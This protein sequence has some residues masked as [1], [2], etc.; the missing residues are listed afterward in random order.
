VTLRS[1]EIWLGNYIRN[2]VWGVT[3]WARSDITNILFCVADHFEPIAHGP[4]TAARERKRMQAWIDGYQKLAGRHWDSDGILPQHT[5]FYPAENYRAEYLEDLSRL[6]RMGL[7]E[8]ELHLHHG[9]DTAASLRRHLE[10]ALEKFNRH[11]ALITQG[12]PPMRTYGFIHGSMALDNSM[13]DPRWCGVNNELQILQETG[14]YADFSMPTAP[15]ISQ[16]RKINAIYYAV[17]DPDTPKSHDT[18]VDAQVGVKGR[19]GLL[20]I[21][22]PL[23]LNWRRRKFGL[24]PRIDNAEITGTYSA[25]PDR[26]RRWVRQAIHV[27]GRPEW[28]V[29]KVSCHGAEE[30]HFGAL[31]GQDA[32]R[33]YS[34]LEAQFRDRNGFSLHYVTARELYNII[35]AAEAGCEGDPGDFR[36]FVIP[37]YLNRPAVASDRRE[38]RGE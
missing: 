20:I 11:G 26:I 38:S 12:E 5:W 7:G 14:C 37:P 16:T 10:D 36:N 2:Y 28:L 22:G 32:E 33:P 8:I 29:V 34:Y 6:C 13:G 21:Q 9:H 4:S 15:A 30:R 19:D 27:Q 23:A 35:K 31:L 25:T 24:L 1:L 18:G 3:T 17:D